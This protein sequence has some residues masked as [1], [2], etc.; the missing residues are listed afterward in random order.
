[1]AAPR[2]KPAPRAQSP[3]QQQQEPADPHLTRYSLSDAPTST[4]YNNISSAVDR[5]LETYPENER[6]L[7]QLVDP[8]QEVASSVDGHSVNDSHYYSTAPSTAP[9]PAHYTPYQPGQYLAPII[10]GETL[11]LNPDPLPLSST[12]TDSFY[13]P[14]TP[15]SAATPLAAAPTEYYYNQD[16]EY[17]PPS[18]HSHVSSY[19]QDTLT[20]GS[21][22]DH[23]NHDTE[24]YASGLY[25][26]ASYRPPRS[27]SPT[28]A[29]DDEDYMIVGNESVHY[30]GYPEGHYNNGEEHTT[31][32]KYY[33]E[34]GYLPDGQAVVFDP[35]PETPTSTIFSLPPEEKT[36]HFG[37]APTGRV[38]RRH[39]TKRRVQL[40][41]GN[42]VVDLDVPPKLVL[43][44]RGEPETMKTRYTAV[45]CDPDDFEKKGFFLRQNESGRRT[46][47]FIVIT[48][49]NVCFI[50]SSLYFL[51][52][53][54][55]RKT[56]F[57]SVGLCMVSCV[58]FHTCVRERTLKHG[59]PML[60][61]R[62]LDS[63]ARPKP[64]LYII[65]LPSGCCLYS[66]RW[67][68]ESP[69]SGARLPHTTRRL[70]AR[71]PHEKQSQR[72]R[73]NGP[74]FRIHH[75]FRT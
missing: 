49:Y 66:S 29:V 30:T 37:P 25:S 69:S 27:R 57:Y 74:S 38:L 65:S 71:R 42:L 47:L 53:H 18:N 62:Y 44:R 64:N 22:L 20:S 63:S 32:E 2:R 39:K 23:F 51:S 13:D 68:Q 58:I 61:K 75:F 21:Q 50:S 16:Q 45:T 19:D 9:S 7:S 72:K 54:H 60:G 17:N 43:P 73:G 4:S 3:I 8:F 36:R 35:E 11:Q 59:V 26:R 1:M 24:A 67:A 48:M 6:P 15:I 5:L 34:R 14:T 28:P 12:Q 70:P 52:H 40:T 31:H 56:K 10:T 55:I 33:S 46:E 41:N